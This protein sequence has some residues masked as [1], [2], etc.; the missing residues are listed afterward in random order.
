MNE[1]NSLNYKSGL[2]IDANFQKNLLREKSNSTPM[3]YTCS[4]KK[5]FAGVYF[6]SGS[7]NATISYHMEINEMS[8]RM[9]ISMQQSF[10]SFKMEASWK[11]AMMLMIDKANFAKM[12]ISQKK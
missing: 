11:R 9:C 10:Y 5:N 4:I 12:R 1:S 2:V 8:M 7:S 3:H 6:M